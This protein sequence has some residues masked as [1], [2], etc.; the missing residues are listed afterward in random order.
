MNGVPFRNA[1]AVATAGPRP[2]QV[3][4]MNQ[5][6]H[7]AAQTLGRQH[8]QQTLDRRTIEQDATVVRRRR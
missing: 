1:M 8:S 4:G 6:E 5:L 7:A 2:R 3:L